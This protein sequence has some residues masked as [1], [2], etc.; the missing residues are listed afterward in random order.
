MI[1]RVLVALDQTSRASAVF[2]AAVEIADRFGAKMWL[3]RVVSLPAEF[4]PAAHVAEAD[5]LPEHLKAEIVRELEPYTAGEHAARIEAVIVSYAAT[6]WR[7]ILEEADGIDADL[8]VIGSHGYRGLDRVLGTT[9]GN[10]ANRAVRN[11]LVVHE[12]SPVTTDP[13]VDAS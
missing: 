10:V 11:V 1:E 5:A 9:A 2:G 6:P 4:P 7:R 12:R 3:L 8:I 13:A